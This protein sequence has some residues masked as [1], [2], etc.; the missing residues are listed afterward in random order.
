MALRL[1][2]SNPNKHKGRKAKTPPI[3]EARIEVKDRRGGSVELTPRE[4]MDKLGQGVCFPQYRGRKGPEHLEVFCKQH[5]YD[6]TKHPL[7]ENYN[8]IC[9]RDSF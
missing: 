9:S 2:R 3:E 1:P 5:G 8:K 7:W 4:L 6:P